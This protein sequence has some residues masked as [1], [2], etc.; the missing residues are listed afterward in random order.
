[1]PTHRGRYAPR[2]RKRCA[3]SRGTVGD[4]EHPLQRNPARGIRYLRIDCITLLSVSRL[5]RDTEQ[6]DVI[7][8][9]ASLVLHGQVM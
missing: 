4:R 7:N 5:L 2:N 6:L 8:K 1:M 9:K 3:F